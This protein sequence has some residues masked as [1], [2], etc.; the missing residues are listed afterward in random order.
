MKN[1]LFVLIALSF[2][3]QLTAQRGGGQGKE[4]IQAVKIAVF[5]EELQLTP[6]EAE[7]FWP[8]FNEYEAK[9]FAIDKQIRDGGKGLDTKSDKEIEKILENRFKLQ[10]Q[11]IDTEREYYQK[12]KKIISLQ[13]IAKIPAAQ[14]KFKKRLVGEMH[15]N[16]PGL[17]END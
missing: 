13:K 4:K 5:T 17:R 3:S 11:K 15:K 2:A 12:F 1:I 10:Q 14:M 9:I 7:K 6:K 8:L 16:K